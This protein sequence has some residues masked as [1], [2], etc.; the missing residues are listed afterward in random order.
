MLTSSS[1]PMEHAVEIA[2]LGKRYGLGG[3]HGGS[4]YDR[5]ARR[6]SAEAPGTI[7]AVRDV[8]LV[9]P[10]GTVFGFI[11]RNGSGKSTLMKLLARVTAPTE[12]EARIVGRV[13]P[14]LQVGVGFHPE[15]SGR[16]NVVLSG[17]ILGM[18]TA[19]IREAAGD[20]F[21]F[22]EIDDFL[23]TP[24]KHYSSGMYMRLAFSVAAHMAAD[25]MLIDEILSVGDAA[26]QKKCHD[27]IRTL[28]S[29]GRT[30]MFVSH[31][32]ASVRQIC[33]RAAVL[34]H[35]Q[36]VFEG[37]PDDAARYY[38]TTILGQ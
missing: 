11:G 26:F 6:R 30:V 28:V 36:L 35:G 25:I 18:S 34:D 31:A 9:V 23:D 2:H 37:A 16:D 24:V 1:T 13:A 15:L 33:D 21:A 19:E 29:Q 17:A 14:L 27:R 38:E 22:A 3:G 12:G 4:L 20:I 8:S 32:M 7:W 10:T 5:F